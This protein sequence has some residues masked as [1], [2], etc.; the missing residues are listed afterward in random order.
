VKIIGVTAALLSIAANLAIGQQQCRPCDLNWPH[1]NDPK[2]NGFVH[3]AGHA[4][5]AVAVYE[6]LGLVVLK[7]S[8][9]LRMAVAAIGLPLLQE[10]V[11][12]ELK[13]PRHSPWREDAVHDF[14]T[15]QGAW[16][17]RLAEHGDW[18][19]AGIVTV[20]WVGGLYVWNYYVRD[21]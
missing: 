4:V 19:L 5:T 9:D 13:F 21:W 2:L 11:I 6:V 1:L 10:L 18:L 16:A 15:Y 7:K 17:V 12:D 20:M 14:F 8:P 3:D